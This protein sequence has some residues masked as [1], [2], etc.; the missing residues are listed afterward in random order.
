MRTERGLLQ[1]MAHRPI[2][3]DGAGTDGSAVGAGGVEPFP[4]SSH[5]GDGAFVDHVLTKM[6]FAT[7]VQC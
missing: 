7:A 4:S 2:A 5:G 3:V 1:L 6:R